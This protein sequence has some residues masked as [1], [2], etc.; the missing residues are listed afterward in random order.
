M[1]TILEE[2][3]RPFDQTYQLNR[4]GKAF[5]YA[6]TAEVIERLN[7]TLGLDGWSFELLEHGLDGDV[8]WVHGRLTAYLPERTVIREQF[9]ECPMSRGRD[10]G[11]DRKGAASDA[12][13]KCAQLLEVG[14]YLSRKEESLR[15]A[16]ARPKRDE[17][18]RSDDGPAADARG[19]GRAAPEPVTRTDRFVELLGRW[20]ALFNE[21]ET[22]GLER[23][24]LPK[25]PTNPT[26]ADLERVGPRL[27]AAV[28]RARRTAEPA[29]RA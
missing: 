16:Q 10:A 21:A 28:E 11:N 6:E 20:T 4:G 22:L 13:K 15:A 12:L 9:G 29:V 26:V 27:K 25:L 7:A 2:L 8:P 19:V 24:S 14:L 18:G 5:D 1:T 17:D 3:K 23:A